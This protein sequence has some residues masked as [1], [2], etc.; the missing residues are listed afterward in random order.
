[1]SFDQISVAGTLIRLSRWLDRVSGPTRLIQ[2]SSDGGAFGTSYVSI[3]VG[4]DS[5]Y[6]SANY[7]RIHLCGRNGGLTEAGLKKLIDRFGAAGVGRFFIWLSPGPDM[8][9]VRS[10]LSAG[11]LLRV[12]HVGYP[13]LVR[14][15]SKPETPASD[16]IVR[17]IGASDVAQMSDRLEHASWPE[18]RRSIGAP[19]IFH[20]VACDGDEL[21]ASA[22]LAIFGG[23]GYL[24]MALTAEPHRRRGAQQALIARRIEIARQC[25]CRVLISETLSFLETSLG[26]LRKA[27]FKPLY[28]KEIYT[29]S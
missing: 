13:T 21:I 12:S 15:V 28:E 19:G 18:F 24:G 22:A 11:G 2:S 20:L 17:E 3:A 9:I 8:E 1:M 14:D 27:G 5:P 4:D 7:N 23:L 16:L 26:N 10:W 29:S 6:A 25:G